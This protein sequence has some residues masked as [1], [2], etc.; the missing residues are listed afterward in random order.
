M[1][2]WEGYKENGK[3]KHDTEQNRKNLITF[4][5]LLKSAYIAE[6]SIDKPQTVI[7]KG[8]ETLRRGCSKAIKSIYPT[9]LLSN[10]TKSS[11]VILNT[12][13]LIEITVSMN[14]PM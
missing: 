2:P 1:L 13:F 5:P 4:S 11:Q 3:V 10:E 7:L 6:L 12:I 14:F 9:T 8:R